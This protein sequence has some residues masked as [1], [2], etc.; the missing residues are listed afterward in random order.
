[1]LE[2][3]GMPSNVTMPS[4]DFSFQNLDF[5]ILFEFSAAEIA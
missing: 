5:G 4:T 3:K 1:M 2:L